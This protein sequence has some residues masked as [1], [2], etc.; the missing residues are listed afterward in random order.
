M[1]EVTIRFEVRQDD[2]NN[3][4]FLDALA[5]AWTRY[6]GNPGESYTVLSDTGAASEGGQS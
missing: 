3:T 4:P 1:R 2:E 5:V 6:V